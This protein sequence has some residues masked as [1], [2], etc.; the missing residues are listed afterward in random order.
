MLP[1]TTYNTLL[2]AFSVFWSHFSGYMRAYVCPRVAQFC[3]PSRSAIFDIPRSLSSLIPAHSG[4]SNV[5]TTQ[6]HIHRQNPTC[7]RH[8]TLHGQSHQTSMHCR[9]NLYRPYITQCIWISCSPTTNLNSWQLMCD[10]MNVCSRWLNLYTL[11]HTHD[12]GDIIKPVKYPSHSC[13]PYRH[14]KYRAD[15]VVCVCKKNFK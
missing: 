9:P 4:I 1:N 3:F 8:S 2:F 6:M 5:S 11:A 10:C 15:G 13:V 12:D 14:Y 7:A